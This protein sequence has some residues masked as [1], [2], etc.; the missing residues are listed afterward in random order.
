MGLKSAQGKRKAQLIFVLPLVVATLAVAQTSPTH[1]EEV[2]RQHYEAAQSAQSAGHLEEAAAEYKAF[3]VEALR[4]LADRRAQAGDFAKAAKLFEQA[5]PF[6]PQ[7]T[8]LLLDRAEALRSAGDVEKAESAVESVLQAD[9]QNARAHFVLGRTLLQRKEAQKAS[10]QIELAVA[11]DPTFE[12]GYLLAIAY[13]D[14]KAPDRAATVF[15]E[16]LAGF[17]DNAAIHMDFGRAYAE[18][19]YPE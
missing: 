3:L 16:M 18:A 4:R 17:G 12:H 5:L 6:A 9:P 1:P 8:S 10:Q 15:K 2:L 7:D 14:L 13:L 11:K 19:G